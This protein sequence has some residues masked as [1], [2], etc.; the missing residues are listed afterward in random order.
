MELGKIT[1]EDF[2]NENGMSFWWASDLMKMLGYD[3]MEKFEKVINRATKAFI[4]LNISHYE[5]IQFSDRDI[6][7][8]KIKDFKLSRFACYLCAMNASPSKPEVAKAQAYFAEQTR[9]LEL[10]M[11]S[12][13][14]IDRVIIREEIIEGNKSLASTA[15]NA[16]VEDYAK[17]YN[18]G[19]IGMY[20][21]MNVQLA[22]RKGIE[23]DQ[24][25]EVMGRTE[26]AANLFR[27]TQTEEKIKSQKVKG[28]Y[29]LEKTHKEVGQLVRDIV[30]KNTG[31]NPED[32]PIEKKLPIVKKELKETNKVMNKA[33]KPPRKK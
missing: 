29:D 11:Q 9:K 7:G 14:Q 5:N 28:Q 33:D 26:L 19:F 1:F 15:K 31:R 3:S 21:M 12:Q 13:D 10:T 18:A 32:L 23:K 20:N 30:K 27:I 6:N 24:L 17:F 25:Y 8:S 22:K 16:K 2:K 4:S